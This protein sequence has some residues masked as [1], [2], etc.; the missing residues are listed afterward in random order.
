MT[1]ESDK[2]MEKFRAYA[3]AFSRINQALDKAFP[4]EA[5]ALE[6]SIICDRLRAYCEANNLPT[7]NS[8]GNPCNL[9]EL[10]NNVEN[11]LEKTPS[12]SCPDL[13]KFLNSAN[14]WRK[15]RNTMIHKVV[16]TEKSGE[17]PEISHKDFIPK[18]MEY[19]KTGK[20]LARTICNI[21]NKLKH[22]AEKHAKESS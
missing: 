22:E 7:I 5:L 14:S 12:D 18:A 3:F 19:A 16:K 6:E 1:E 11:H 20:D 15:D 10:I 9:Y 21:S 4:L 13:S 8:R 2:N 17:A